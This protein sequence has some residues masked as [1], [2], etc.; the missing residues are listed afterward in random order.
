MRPQS[1]YEAVLARRLDPDYGALHVLLDGELLPEASLGPWEALEKWNPMSSPLNRN[2]RAR[3]ASM[4]RRMRDEARA[5]GLD[6]DAFD[7]PEPPEFVAPSL[8][9]LPGLARQARHAAEEARIDMLH[10]RRQVANE[11]QAEAGNMPAE[12][13]RASC[14][15]RVCQYV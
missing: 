2:Q 5:A 4:R 15:G 14:R 9:E 7:V 13:G 1:H 12:I 11:L 10:A 3:A 6:A 8:Q